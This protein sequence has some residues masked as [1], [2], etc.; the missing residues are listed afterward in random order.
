MAAI[1]IF[2]SWSTS[3]NVGQCRTMSTVSYPSWPWPKIWGLEVGIAAPF[4]SYIHFRFDG[5]HLDFWYLVDVW[6]WR[7]MPDNVDSVISELAMAENMGVEVGIAAP[8]LIV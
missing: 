5:R 3:G 1:L 7:T 8:S 6:Q 2:G 4:K